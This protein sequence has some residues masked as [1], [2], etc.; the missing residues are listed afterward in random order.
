MDFESLIMDAWIKSPDIKQFE[1]EAELID[2]GTYTV[3]Y[4]TEPTIK[5]VTFEIEVA[6]ESNQ[7][8]C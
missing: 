7:G 3:L 1:G 6:K 5:T 4:G 2:E 8:F